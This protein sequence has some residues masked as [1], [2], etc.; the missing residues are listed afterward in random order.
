MISDKRD[1]SDF[2]KFPGSISV[3]IYKFP[4]LYYKDVAEN[5]R[6]WT[7]FVRLVKAPPKGKLPKHE[8][9]WDL[10]KENQIPIVSGY[11]KDKDLPT[12]VISQFWVETGIIGG[13]I[14]RHPPTYPN[15]TNVG[16]SN[17]RNTF[18][19]SLVDAR[20]KYLKKLEEGG[21]TKKEFES[22]KKIKE[23]FTTYFPMLARKYVDEK[24]HAVWPAMSQPKLDGVRCLAFLDVNPHKVDSS[25]ISYKNVIL[26]TRQKKEFQG[27]NHIRRVLLEPLITM[28]NESGVSLYLDGEFYK[29]GKALQ[30]ISGEVRNIEKNSNVSKDSVKYWIFDCFYPTELDTP[31]KERVEI[32]EDFFVVYDDSPV[33]WDGSELTTAI[34]KIGKSFVKMVPYQTHKNEKE[35]MEQYKVWIA[36]KYEGLMYRNPNGEYLGHPT[37]TGTFLRSRGLLKL[38]MRYSDEFEVDGFTEGTKGRDKGAIMWICKTK[39]GKKTFHATPKNTTLKK[40]YE[41]FKKITSDGDFDEKYKGREMTIEYEDLSKDGVPLRAKSVGFRDYE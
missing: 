6:K 35:M 8:H 24:K 7:V 4:T 34:Q 28:Y 13:K 9:D 38:K 32:L 19:Q 14:S 23:K 41:L 12:K 30:D 29:H 16:K 5:V 31:F 37:K 22:K 27:F 3:G 25:K 15:E 17:E 39:D 11:L 40:R 18:K 36:Q 33:D 2:T 20:S 1:F 10:L 21:R 26:A